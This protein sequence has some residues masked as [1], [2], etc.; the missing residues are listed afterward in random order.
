MYTAKQTFIKVCFAVCFDITYKIVSPNWQTIKQ[1]S[2]IKV[3]NKY[4][5]MLKFQVSLK[6]QNT[7]E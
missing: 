7:L 4:K 6:Y 3:L 1:D 5:L 2:L